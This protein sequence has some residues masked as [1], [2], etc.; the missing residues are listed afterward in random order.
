MLSRKGLLLLQVSQ[1]A[2]GSQQDGSE[3]E[4]LAGLRRGDEQ[5]FAALVARYHDTMV[6]VACGI[7]RQPALAEDVVQDTWLAVLR[8][9]QAFEARASLKTWLFRILINRARTAARREARTVVFS[10][11]FGDRLEDEEVLLGPEQFQHPLAPG[12][13]TEP[14]KSW[15][16]SPD[17][18]ML[19]AEARCVLEAALAALPPVQRAVITLRDVEGWDSAEVCNALGLSAVHQR[20]LLHRA[21]TKV[22]RAVDCYFDRGAQCTR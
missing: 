15:D 7:V 2:P 14:V 9:I 8:G 20:V 5:A 17:Q 21:R 12:H 18:R 3:A 13:W 6:R 22:R 10:D 19:G 1:V 4:L 16:A 11:A